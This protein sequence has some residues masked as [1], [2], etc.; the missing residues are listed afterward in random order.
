MIILAA[1]AAVAGATL[2]ASPEMVVRIAEIEV[3]PAALDRYRALLAQEIEASIRLEP[4]VLSLQAVALKDQPNQIRILEIYASPASYQAHLKA[5]HFLK[6]KNETAG[7]VRTLT[8][9]ETTPILLRSKTG[10][11]FQPD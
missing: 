9:Q 3:D 6:Y 8:L 4:G 5:P 7:M 11:A 2:S 1:L 10:P